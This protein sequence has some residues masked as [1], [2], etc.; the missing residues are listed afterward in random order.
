MLFREGDPGD[1]LFAIAQ[2]RVRISR[3]LA[4][5]EEAFAILAPGEIFGEMAILDPTSPGRSA[6]ARAHEESVLLV[7]AR[8]R[9]EK[10]E[11]SDR[12]GARSSPSSSAGSRRADV[13][14]PPIGSHGGG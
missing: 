9:F 4:G 11:R 12:K 1:A 13:S 8:P 14:R 7:L 6:D 2:G 10:L 3:R 5:G